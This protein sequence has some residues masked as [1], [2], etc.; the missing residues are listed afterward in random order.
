MPDPQITVNGQPRPLAGVPVHT[1]AL[2]FLRGLGLTGAKEGCAEGECGACAVLVARPDG[3]GTRWTPVNACLVPAAA[4]DGQEVVTAEGLGTPGRTCTR[5]RPS[6]PSGAARSAATA[7]PGFVCSMAAEYYRADRGR[8]DRPTRARPQRLRPPRDRRQ[9]VP[10]H[11][12]PPDPRRR[13]G[14]RRARRRRP[15]RRAA[16]A[17]CAGAR[18]DP[19]STASPGRPTSPRRW[20]CWPSTPTPRS[21]PARPT[22][23]S[24]S[25]CAAAGR[26]TSSRSTGC[27]SC[28]T[29]RR[30][31]TTRRDR[32]GAHPE[33]GRARPRRTRCRCWTQVWPLFA[34]R[35]IRNSAT[36]G[37]NL[38]TASPIGDLAPALLALD[39][40]L[41]LAS[42]DGDRE[43]AL[44]DFFTGYR[45]TVLGPDELVRSVRVPT[46]LAGLTTF[47]KIAKRRYDDISSV[48]VGFALDV[49]DGT[50]VRARIGL[51]GVAATPLRA[52]ATEAVLEGRPWT[53]ETVEAAAPCWPAR[54]RRS[55]TSGRARP[56]ARRC[57]ATPCASRGGRSPALRVAREGSA[58]ALPHESADLHVTGHALYTDDL[59]HR[60]PRVLHAHPVCSPHAHA[61][62]TRLDVAPAL[63]VAGVVRV[64]TAADVP[65]VNDAGVKHDEPLFPDEVMFV[66]HAV[67]WVLGETLEAARLGAAAVEVDYEPLPAIV[68]RRRGDRGRELPGRPARRRARRRRAGPG[69]RPP[70]SSAAS[71]R[72]RGRSTSTS[73]PTRRWR[74][75]TRAA[76][77]SCRAAPSTPPRPRR[78]SRTCSGLHSHHVTVQCLRMG[79]GFGGKEMQPHGFAAV[80]ALGA[81]LTGR[82]VR[83]RLTRTQDMTM[84]GKRHGFHAAVAGRLRR[85]RPAAR[86]SRRR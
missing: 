62:V 33:R 65:G 39:A 85:R 68:S 13:L 83:L 76:R 17:P 71:P 38:A 32:R 77:S 2:D 35:L 43:V 9:P 23:A 44:A 29:P 22:G 37:G 54:A 82:P 19:A 51:G 66:G 80:A 6:S 11:R 5:C 3:D 81:T 45:A 34:S 48:A 20:P 15:A 36:I 86:R 4:L 42:A 27:P 10:L 73:R 30:P 84:T 7:R 26:R 25:T 55:T 63:A 78:S 8:R 74:W 52:L 41:V 79:G 75:S 53:E 24:R 69:R 57:S 58:S 18:R 72:W 59:V 1:N 31:A 50:V 70:T 60:T 12:L 64:L 40:S 61:R 14:A 47:H 16:V 49:V 46:P 67:C 56:T 21:S 28:A